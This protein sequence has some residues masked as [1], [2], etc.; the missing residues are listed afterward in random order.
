MDQHEFWDKYREKNPNFIGY[1]GYESALE[2]AGM[3]VLA[4]RSFGDYQGT[5]YVFGIYNNIKGWVTGSYGS[6]SGCDAWEAEF[7]NYYTDFEYEEWFQ[8]IKE[9]G[10][11]YL[12][13]SDTTTILEPIKEDQSI[14]ISA[15]KVS[16]WILSVLKEHDH[17]SY[18]EFNL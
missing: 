2:V 5:W 12:P 18:M 8:K 4:G 14:D 1:G 13:L 11:K 15:D 9:F 17:E 10:E 7:D 16:E 3:T 6:C